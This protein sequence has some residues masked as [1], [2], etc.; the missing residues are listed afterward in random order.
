MVDQADRR[1]CETAYER[2]A[3]EPRLLLPRPSVTID[4]PRLKEHK[5]ENAMIHVIATIEIAPGRRDDFLTEFHQIIPLVRDEEGCLDYGP[6]VDVETN[7]EAQPEARKDVV[8]IVERWESLEHLEAH[9]VA[10][11]M[12]EYRSRVKDIVNKAVLRILEPA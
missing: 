11:H 10:P 12:I 9:L 4:E 7:L 8:T 1:V 2:R 3:H 5:S 6:T